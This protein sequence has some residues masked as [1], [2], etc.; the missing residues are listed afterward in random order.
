MSDY[1]NVTYEALRHQMQFSSSDDNDSSAMT[2]SEQY[3]YEPKVVFFGGE[4]QLT[5][6]FAWENSISFSISSSSSSFVG[7]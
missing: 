2:A 4:Q 3:S 1:D 6:I 7:K 5:A